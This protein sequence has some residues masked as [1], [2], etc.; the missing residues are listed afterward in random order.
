M[1][2]RRIT[3]V[4]S[5]PIVALLYPTLERSPKQKPFPE[6]HF[7]NTWVNHFH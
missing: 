7:L 6:F 3:F 4:P 5:V 2:T 1:H